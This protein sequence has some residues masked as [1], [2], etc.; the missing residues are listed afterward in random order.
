MY[1]K[2]LT[3]RRSDYGLKISTIRNEPYS[4]E[5]VELPDELK[6]KIY[7]VDY[8]T[9][10]FDIAKNESNF[11]FSKWSR[12]FNLLITQFFIVFVYYMVGYFTYHYYEGWNLLDSIYF[13]TSTFTTVGLSNFTPEQNESK[14]FTIFH[15]M[16]GLAMV[17]TIMTTRVQVIF[18]GIEHSFIKAIENKKKIHSVSR[19]F[20][21][22]L[23]MVATILFF[24]LF[25]ALYYYLSQ[26]K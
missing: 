12:T 15:L 7:I 3:R 6:D 16:V 1:I 23:I 10:D 4:E 14:L 18:E 8:S 9:Q 26:V 25:G 19:F 20:F 22:L 2:Y 17:Y 5:G 11:G 21:E 13:V 24:M